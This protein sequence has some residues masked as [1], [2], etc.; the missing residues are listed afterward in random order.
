ML[1]SDVPVVKR[2]KVQL[3]LNLVNSDNYTTILREFVVCLISQANIY[4]LTIFKDYTDDVGDD[5]LVSAAIHALG[6][7]ARL[8]PESAQQCLTSLVNFIRND[9]GNT[10]HIAIEYVYPLFIADVIVSSAV[11]ELKLLI[12]SGLTTSSE[13]V[14]STGAVPPKVAIEIV[15]ALATKLEQ[16]NHPSAR[17]CVLWLT[18]Q[19]A[20]AAEEH[21]TPSPIPGVALWAPDTLRRVAK[22]FSSEVTPIFDV[23]K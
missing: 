4:M 5:I 13:S 16:I 9:S 18:G 11:L 20:G 12:Q 6:R 7:C 17:A 23:R 1:S 2:I 15:A 3:L 10:E 22:T 21:G 14:P 8:V 19:Y